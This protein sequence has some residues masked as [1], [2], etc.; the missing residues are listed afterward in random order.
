MVRR[1]YGQYRWLH[2]MTGKHAWGHKQLMPGASELQKIGRDHAFNKHP[3]TNRQRIQ[4]AMCKFQGLSKR[5]QREMTESAELAGLDPLR[6]RLRFASG[7]SGTGQRRLD[8]RQEHAKAAARV[9]K[10]THL[11]G[12]IGTAKA[13]SSSRHR[14]PRRFRQFVSPRPF[15]AKPPTRAVQCP[16]QEFYLEIPAA[17][18]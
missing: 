17:F 5:F 16:E 18:S 11:A 4:T 9:L 3:A 15:E 12:F 8:E 6:W 7:G 2:T 1:G 10:P 13:V 14:Y